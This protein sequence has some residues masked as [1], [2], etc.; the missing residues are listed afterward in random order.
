VD[1]TSPTPFISAQ[2]LSERTV[3]VAVGKLEGRFRRFRKI[4]KATTS[5]FTS[6]YLS[7]YLFVCSP[8]CLSRRKEQLGSYWMN[9]YK[10][11]IFEYFAKIR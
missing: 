7:V 5:F 2:R 11:V 8:V 3:L 9:F 4:A 10:N 6:V 1:I